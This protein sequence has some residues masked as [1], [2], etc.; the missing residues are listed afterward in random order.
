MTNDEAK[1]F[2]LVICIVVVLNW[3]FVAC[4]FCL[5][6]FGGCGLT[7]EDPEHEDGKWMRSEGNMRKSIEE[8][9]VEMVKKSVKILED[10]GAGGREEGTKGGQDI[11]DLAE[12]DAR[13]SLNRKREKNNLEK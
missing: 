6:W 10:V 5:C 8:Q 4:F 9:E 12:V 13:K 11:V 7:R 2:L 1:T 3:V